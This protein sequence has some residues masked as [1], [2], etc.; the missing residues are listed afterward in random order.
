MTVNTV[1]FLFL[2][3]LVFATGYSSKCRH[4]S[5]LEALFGQTHFYYHHHY[6]Y[7]RDALRR[8]D[9]ANDDLIFPDQRSYPVNN[10]RK[11]QEQERRRI[12]PPQRVRDPVRTENSSKIV[13]RY[14]VFGEIM[15]VQMDGQSVRDGVVFPGPAVSRRFIPKEIPEECKK[16]GFC[17]EIPDY[18]EEVVNSL[19][20]QI[21]RSKYHPDE[22]DKQIEIA[23]R[24]GPPDEE[25]LCN[26]RERV[27]APKMAPD[28][29]GKWYYIVNQIGTN[30]TPLQAFR[31]EICSSPSRSC[32]SLAS[33]TIGYESY[34]KQKFILRNMTALDE[35]G[36]LVDKQFKLPSCCSCVVKRS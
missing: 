27:I 7:Q 32:S 5:E 21:D 23:Q 24:I 13:N 34:C 9:V 15:R 17:E 20:S 12:A 26:F 6:Y 31:V 10:I 30:S 36:N 25:E 16:Q 14:P 8:S 2:T 19:I 1:Q 29:D 3:S 22:L 33:F 28:K 11:I 18:P 35:N 4:P